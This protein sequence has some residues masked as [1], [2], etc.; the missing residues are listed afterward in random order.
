VGGNANADLFD[1]AFRAARSFG[2]GVKEAA[3]LHN[4]IRQD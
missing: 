1:R 2:E 3:S 4:V